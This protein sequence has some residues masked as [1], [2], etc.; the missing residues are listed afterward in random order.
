M[1]LP[2]RLT[3]S[4]SGETRPTF[5][6]HFRNQNVGLDLHK[7]N[8]GSLVARDF[9]FTTNLFE[10][11]SMNHFSLKG[12]SSDPNFILKRQPNATKFL[13]LHFKVSS[14]MLANINMKY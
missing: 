7:V 1:T 4:Y 13:L 12:I 11:L 3:I 14:T 10:T 2:V 9:S 8:K 5:L 6:T